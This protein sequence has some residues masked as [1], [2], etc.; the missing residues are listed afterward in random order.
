MA[1]LFKSTIVKQVASSP[2]VL[3]YH[4]STVSQALQVLNQNRILSAPIINIGTN[5][6]L[7]S[8]DV[9]DLLSFLLGGS[10]DESWKDEVLRR[11]S[12]P[13]YYAIDFSMKNPFTPV[14]E[15][16]PLNEVVSKF[17]AV[18]L[19]RVPVV[20]SSSKVNSILSQIDVIT[21]LKNQI[22]NLTDER[23]LTFSKRLLS[24]LEIKTEVIAVP[25]DVKLMN[26]F[27]DIA[28]NGISGI[29]VVDENGKLTGNL[30]AS[31]FEG[32]SETNFFEY[33][34]KT[35]GQI[36]RNQQL[37]TLKRTNTL[38]EA[39]R[40]LDKFKIHRVYVVNNEGIPVSLVTTTDIMRILT[41][42]LQL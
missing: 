41:K 9:L 27:N 35:L 21:F 6:C 1:N 38:E 40:K 28:V 16:L 23:F 18:G 10:K 14:S 31:D 19:H 33:T 32:L 39:I 26:A 17:F 30:S 4:T 12:L 20:D 2:V 7:G 37:I 15:D 8:I 13:V 36:T 11:F 22:D 3:I 24:T 5:T 34:E 29:A 42:E 25:Q